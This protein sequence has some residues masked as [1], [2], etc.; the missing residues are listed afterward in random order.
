MD[1]YICVN[2]L[3]LTSRI[4][5]SLYFFSKQNITVPFNTKYTIKC[6]IYMNVCILSYFLQQNHLYYTHNHFANI[7]LVLKTA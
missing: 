6:Y 3:F 1:V 4:S 7:A 5:V 2:L